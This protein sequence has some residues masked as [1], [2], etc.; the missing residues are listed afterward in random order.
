[1]RCVA[2]IAAVLL[3]VSPSAGYAE[4][5]Q[6][7]SH[8]Y[9]VLF[10]FQRLFIGMV[11]DRPPDLSTIDSGGRPKDQFVVGIDVDR[12][13]D[14][15]PH[16]FDFVQGG[17]TGRLMGNDGQW[18]WADLRA[19]NTGHADELHITRGF[20]GE[21][22]PSVLEGPDVFSTFSPKDTTLVVSVDFDLLGWAA[23]EVPSDFGYIIETYEYGDGRPLWQQGGHYNPTSAS[24]ILFGDVN[25]DLQVDGL[26]IEPFVDVMLNGP[27]QAEAD[28]NKDQTVNGLDVD[29]FVAAIVGGGI[30]SVP[31]PS[32][33]LLCLV[34][35]GTAGGWRKWA[36]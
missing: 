28:M 10:E 3:A 2:G 11:F 23:D 18:S 5:L 14:P 13:Y 25:L 30:Q 12:F 4:K 19:T 21:L 17:G 16:V 26:D 9:F 33:F 32:T 8:S 15:D 35:L 34:A 1:M 36:A 7:T 6:V 22:L 31:E 27:Y 20:P 24:P 29:P